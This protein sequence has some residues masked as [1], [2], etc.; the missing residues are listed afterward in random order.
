MYGNWVKGNPHFT[1]GGL[2]D[3]T[4]QQVPSGVLDVTQSLGN[5]L[6]QSLLAVLV[7]PLLC[8]S[9]GKK[10]PNARHVYIKFLVK[11]GKWLIT[12][13]PW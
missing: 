3:K 8:L 7:C 10:G 4:Q 1:F 12:F 13:C 11:K 2:D 5:S 6:R 9:V